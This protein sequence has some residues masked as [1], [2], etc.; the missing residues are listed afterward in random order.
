[1]CTPVTVWPC[2][3]RRAAATEESTPPDI[4]TKI[5]ILLSVEAI[6]MAAGSFSSEFSA[7]EYELQHDV[8]PRNSILSSLVMF[9]S[10]F[11]SGFIP[12]FPYM[13]VEISTAFWL[14]IAL[15]LVSLF[16]LGVLRA[17]ISRLHPFRHGLEMSAIGGIAI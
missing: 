1:M 13:I 14:S 16:L 10:Y 3:L 2:S 4:A 11:I 6:S 15:S 9:L 12:L 17:K 7:E 8:S 5:F